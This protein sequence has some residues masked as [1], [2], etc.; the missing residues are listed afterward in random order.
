MSTPCSVWTTLAAVAALTPGA[1]AADGVPVLMVSVDGMKPEYVTRADTHGLKIPFLRS[2]K[3]E[4]AYADGVEGVW[5]TI[6]YPSHTTLLTGVSPAEHGI[7]NNLE[8]DPRHTFG[9]AWFWYAHDIRVPTL[10]QVAHQAGMVTASVGWPVSVGATDVD[11][12][13]PEYWRIFRPTADLNPAD[14][15]LMADLSRPE[16]LLRGMLASLGPYLMG[17]DTSAAADEIKTRYALEILR[18]RKPRFMTVHLSSLDE[19]QHEHGPFSSE[20]DTDIEAIDG[21]L[22]RLAVGARSNDP[23]AVMVIVS[24]HGFEE[25]TH[26]T[27]LYIP[28]IQAGLIDI[29]TDSDG[30]TPV[31]TGWTAVPWLAGGM[32]AV[33]LKDAADEAVRGRVRDLLQMLSANPASGVAAILE[34]DAVLERGGFPTASFVVV[35]KAGYYLGTHIGGPLVTDF[36]SHG[37]HGFAPGDPEMRSALFVAGRGIARHRDLGVVDM[38]Q[39]APTVAGLLDVPLPSPRA[40]PLPVR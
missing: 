10:W 6:T 19:S 28:F 27:H 17:N 9:D 11:F 39:I 30:K 3:A 4:G 21:M 20:A 2:L 35:M 38:R 7:Y 5:P 8:F 36:A 18:A 15:E 14:R 12:L 23:A 37:G 34:R 29:K 33:V 26:Q 1:A 22:S 13:I 32:A 25:L 16:G 24:D 40:K 31:I